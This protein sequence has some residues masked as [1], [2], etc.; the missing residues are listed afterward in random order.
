MESK[1]DCHRRAEQSCRFEKELTRK[2]QETGGPT[3]K[4]S[5]SKARNAKHISKSQTRGFLKTSIST[6]MGTQGHA[7]P[8]ASRARAPPVSLAPE[9]CNPRPGG[10]G[11]YNQDSKT[12]PSPSATRD[13]PGRASGPVWADTTLKPCSQSARPLK[14]TPGSPATGSGPAKPTHPY[15]PGHC[16]LCN[17]RNSPTEVLPG[18]PPRKL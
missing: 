7:C 17:R 18:L 10:S 11:R 13:R 15:S 2:L 6:P 1:P 12:R 8:G 4:L 9:I 16:L 5:V 14:L 3:S